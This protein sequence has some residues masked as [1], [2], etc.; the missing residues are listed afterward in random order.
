MENQRIGLHPARRPRAR[1]CQEIVRTGK[2]VVPA[3]AGPRAKRL[4]CLGSRSRGN[5]EKRASSGGSELDYNLAGGDPGPAV[6][7]QIVV[8]IPPSR[9]MPLNQLQFPRAAPFLYTL[10]AEDRIGHGLVKLDKH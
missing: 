1:G 2:F 3:E 8:K 6:L 7:R 9:I 10:F 5:D 4:K